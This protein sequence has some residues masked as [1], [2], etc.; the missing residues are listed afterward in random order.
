GIWHIFE[1]HMEILVK[2]LIKT[3]DFQDAKISLNEQIKD[4]LFSNQI[5]NPHQV[6]EVKGI[7]QGS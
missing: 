2:V 1:N 6:V 4:A 5:L 3:A 7:K